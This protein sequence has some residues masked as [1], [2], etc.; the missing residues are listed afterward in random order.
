MPRQ[1]AGMRSSFKW[2]MLFVFVGFGCKEIKEKLLPSFTVNIPAIRLTIPVLPFTQ[3]KEVPVGAL[4]AHMNMD[5]TI[6]ANTAGAFGASAVTSVKIQQIVF[7]LEN[8][9]AQNNLSNFETGRMRIFSDN[10]TSATDIAIIHF[11]Q[12]YTDSLTITPVSSP[13][14]SNYLRG[15]ELSYNIYWKNRRVTSKKL[16]LL[17]KVTVSVQ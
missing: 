1:S 4:K 3:D 10:D 17:I 7:L 2:L 13:D 12:V 9:D 14:I 11:P 8:A 6:R 16:K 5:S 15:S